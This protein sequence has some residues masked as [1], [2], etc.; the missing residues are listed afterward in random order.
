MIRA[1]IS[2]WYVKVSKRET[3]LVNLEMNGL[4]EYARLVNYLLNFVKLNWWSYWRCPI[5]DLLN[6]LG[7]HETSPWQCFIV[8]PLY[9][10]ILAFWLN[11]FYCSNLWLWKFIKSISDAWNVQIKGVKWDHTPLPLCYLSCT[12]LQ[13]DICQLVK[14]LIGV[15]A[16]HNLCCGGESYFEN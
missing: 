6:R 3:W 8:E 7:T 11:Y 10:G 2:M 9:Y 15:W 14:Q 5:L 4:L 1:K 12:I 16:H 13:L